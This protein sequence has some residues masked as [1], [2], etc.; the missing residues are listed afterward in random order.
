MSIITTV[1]GLCGGEPTIRGMR[2]TVRDVVEYIELYGSRERVLR[3]LPDL[4]EGDIDAAMDY[5][6]K[7]RD[8][9]NRYRLEEEESEVVVE[10]V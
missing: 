1:P 7:H 2:I 5:Y 3:A 9:I 6:R 4:T 10:A 8:E